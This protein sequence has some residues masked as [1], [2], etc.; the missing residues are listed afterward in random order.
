[1]AC[2]LAAVSDN[3]AA[4]SLECDEFVFSFNWARFVYPLTNKAGYGIALSVA[5]FTM[6][7][8]RRLCSHPGGGRLADKQSGKGSEA[9]AA[10]YYV[11]A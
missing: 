11:A 5:G 6:V 4:Y 8:N 3:G 7:S 10:A 2:P 9:I 1:M